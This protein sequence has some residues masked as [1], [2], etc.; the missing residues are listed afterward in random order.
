[1]FVPAVPSAI[2]QKNGFGCRPKPCIS[3]RGSD[4]SAGNSSSLTMPIEASAG[5]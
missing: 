4:S 1:M 3:G 5:S 2:S